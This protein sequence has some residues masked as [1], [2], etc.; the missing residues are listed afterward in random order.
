MGTTS[1]L[2]RGLV[3]VSMAVLVTIWLEVREERTTL[4]ADLGFAVAIGGRGFDRAQA[5]ATDA[6]GNVYTTGAFAGTV[7]F[8]PGAG[9]VA[10]TSAGGTDVFVAKYTSAGALVWA[11]QLAGNIIV[12]G[13]GVAV[14]KQGNVYISGEFQ[15]TADF[16]PGEGVFTLTSAGLRDGFV[17][18]LDSGG[19]FAWARRLGGGTADAGAGVAVDG[20]GN[21]YITGDFYDTADFASGAGTVTLTSAGLNDG[22]VAKLDSGGTFV[23][24]RQLGGSINDAGTR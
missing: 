16:D 18:K 2:Q 12:L 15:D 11:R 10:L 3:A 19:T 21:V 24:V 8:D 6:A 17:A 20:Q 9:T 7:D 1:V 14:D 4:A 23:W 22:F 5:V 13:R